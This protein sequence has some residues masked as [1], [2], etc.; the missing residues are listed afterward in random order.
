MG[1]VACKHPFSLADKGQSLQWFHGCFD[2]T[3]IEFHIVLVVD[4]LRILTTRMV[5][6][7]VLTSSDVVVDIAINT[8]EEE[9][10]LYREPRVSILRS[11]HEFITT[12]T[13]KILV[14]YYPIGTVLQANGIELVDI[15]WTP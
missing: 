12:L 14:T 6:E 8:L 2:V 15:G 1:Q 7:A 9:T 11:Q 13:G 5:M 4:K 10:W 3:A